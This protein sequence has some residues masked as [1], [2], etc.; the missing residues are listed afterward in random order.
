MKDY[1]AGLQPAFRAMLGRFERKLEQAGIKVRMI[2]GLRSMEQQRRLYAIGRR[3]IAGE[4]IVTRARAGYSYHNFGLAADYAVAR[5]SQ[6]QRGKFGA[7]AESVGLTW[8]GRWKMRDY[9]HVESRALPLAELRVRH[10]ADKRA[11]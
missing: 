5:L 10:L 6:Q 2:C 9:G 1:Y 3:G 11:A 7:L 4:R 8:G